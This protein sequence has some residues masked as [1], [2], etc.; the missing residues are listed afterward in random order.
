MLLFFCCQVMC[1]SS[2]PHGPQQFCFPCPKCWSFSFTI[3]PSK[4][5]SG[6]I[7]FRINWLDLPA[8]QGNLNHLLQHHNLNASIFWLSAFFMV[9]L[10]HLT[11]LT[12]VRK[13]MSPLFNALSRF[14]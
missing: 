6:L 10:N 5:Y 8:V 3:S 13:V 14:I 9:Q 11:I 12:F 7:S 1:D 2:Q 4:E